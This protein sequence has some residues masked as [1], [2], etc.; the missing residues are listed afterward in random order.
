[1]DVQELIALLPEA[2]RSDDESL[3]VLECLLGSP[4][5]VE[6]YMDL[7]LERLG[8]LLDPAKCPDETVRYL[9]QNVG[10][11]RDLPATNLLTTAQV[12]SLITV[13][14]YLWKLKG[15][16]ASWRA[17]V[18]AL[19]GSRTLLLDWFYLR[20]VTGTAREVHVIPAPGSAPSGHYAPPEFVTDLWYQ[21][22][23]ALADPAVVGRL[24]DV[25]RGANERINLYPALLVDDLQA[26]AAL[27]TP[28]GPGM[29]G[30]DPLI[31]E[32][33][34]AGNAGFAI[35]LD[36]IAETWASYH[37]FMRLRGRG[38]WAVTVYLEETPPEHGYVV[39]VD[40]GLGTVTLIRRVAGVDVVLTVVPSGPLSPTYPY[41][42]TFEA[43]TDA[44]STTIRVILEGATLL[45]W[46]D[47]APTRRV[48][49]SIRWYSAPGPSNRLALQTALVWA[50]GVSPV[51]VG[52]NP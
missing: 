41:H 23:L 16:S 39:R 46:F 28:R 11:G 49:G 22:P 20:T 4:A 1:M 43:W 37:A 2:L 30:Y 19:T 5:L 9:A 15:C 35:A 27:W 44:L 38:V 33:R 45:T 40:Q 24:L 29:R 50:K 13:A 18:T 7:R 32:L 52:P 51:R 31:P 48:R 47:F 36:G 14:V 26:G 34:A 17:I 21:D 25:M 10:L 3:R 6:T 8:E 12:R 42:W